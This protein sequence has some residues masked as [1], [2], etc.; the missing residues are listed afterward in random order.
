MRSF[1]PAPPPAGAL[2]LAAAAAVVLAYQI[3]L[4]VAMPA[5]SVLS[6]LGFEGFYPGEGSYRWSRGRGRVVF[7][8]PGPGVRGQVEVDVAGWRPRGQEPPAIALE[9]AGTRIEARPSRQGQTITL[10]VATRGWWRSELELALE[11]ETF[12]PG[13]RDPRP[14]GVR[15]QSVRF[16]PEGPVLW[17]RR[18]PLRAPLVAA[19]TVLLFTVALL[20]MGSPP[21]RVRSLGTV[22]VAAFGLGYAF[23]RP[24]AAWSSTPLLA[25]AVIVAFA[26]GVTP[27]AV[28][29]AAAGMRASL[30]AWAQ[31]AKQVLSGGGLALMLAGAAAVATAHRAQPGLDVDVGSGREVPLARN[32]GPFDAAGGATF[33]QAMRGAALDLRDFGS[34]DWS[35]AVTAAVGGE[36]RPLV[37]ARARGVESE[38]V[39]GEGWTTTV[40]RAHAPW[41]WRAG[42]VLEFPE[43]SDGADLRID[44]VRIE[45]AASWPSACT[46]ALVVGAALLVGVAVGA[47]GLSSVA[48]LAAAAMVLGAETLALFRDPVIT[49]PFAATFCAIAALGSVL[50]AVLSGVAAGAPDEGRAA[51]PPPAAQAAAAAGF[52]AF[53]TTTASPLYR[54]GHFGFHS[55]IAEQ[56]WQGRFLLYYLPYPG[57][58]LSRQAQWG[59]II[60]PHPALFHTLVAPLAALPD[61][62]FALGVKLVLA[63]WLAGIVLVAAA[64]A[65][66]AGGPSAGAWTGV[67]AAGLVP[68]YQL[69]GLGHLMTILGCLTM[70]A[71]MA[72]LIL[73]LDRL[74]QPRSWAA[75]VALLSLCFLAYTAG[76][77]FAAFAVA[78]AVPFVFRAE[79]RT[80]R[81][82]VAAGLAAA[83]IAFL[84]YY[85]NWTWPFL[86]QS[87]PRI[88]HGSGAPEGEGTPVIKRLLALPHKLNYSYGSALVPVLGLAGLARARALRGWPLLAAWAAV[89]PV[90][91]VADLFFNLLLKHHYFT[92]APVAVGGGLLL[93]ALARRG[94]AGRVSAGVLLGLALLLG[95]QAALDAALGRIP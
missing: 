62:W 48:S 72:Y 16:V 10:P 50:A 2:A 94:P 35:V 60:V 73:R 11:S 27:R 28:G 69:L 45:R 44:R 39:L 43:G 4:P 74:R 24:W 3:Q 34:G 15:V 13:P 21:G 9:A 55:Q 22:L 6:T 53:F 70:A 58:M 23:A 78:A 66:A 91:S 65:T 87:V 90:F 14:L 59:D 49:I 76:L 93:S 8:D 84:L 47:A 32:L 20:R 31:G 25:I 77:L 88:L 18:P 82:L 81:A 38:A 56:I 95:L 40:L 67:L 75:A 29:A 80:A 42:L 46:V 19:L 89:L 26:A 41:G 5:G 86:S 63:V 85:V 71:A 51:V 64:L 33:R 7:R 12:H 68:F 92:A 30:R 36:P 79:P 57:S 37:L 1:R 17:P 52:V 83:A 61:P 54:G